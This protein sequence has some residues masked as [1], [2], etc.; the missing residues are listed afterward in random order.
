M[1]QY[2]ICYLG[3]AEPATPEEGKQHF[4]KYNE[5]LTAMGDAVVNPASPFKDTTTVQSDGTVEPGSMSAISGFTVIDVDSM[6][7]ALEH[8]KA[9]PFLELGGALE[10]SELIQMPG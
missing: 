2:I 9:C 6:E 10:V 1:A 5:W 7:A 4:A 8:A 3:G